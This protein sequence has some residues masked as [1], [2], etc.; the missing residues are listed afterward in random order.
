M[1]SAPDNSRL[2]FITGLA[3]EAKLI[4]EAFARAGKAS[5]R[6][7]CDGPGPR[8]AQAAA[9]RLAAD[10]AV[11]LVSF[12]IC[13][14]LDPELRPGD[15]LLADTILTGDGTRHPASGEQNRILEARLA[16]LGLDIVTGPLLGQDR[17][18]VSAADKSTR[19]AA[20]AALAVDME[21]H[22]VA[23]AAEAAGLPFLTLRAIA[24]PAARSLPQAAL[25]AI[26]P[27]GRLQ[28][29]SAIAAMYLRPWESLALVRLA[30]ETRLAF[31]TL[32]KVAAELAEPGAGLFGGD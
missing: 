5:P 6:L 31:D 27:D 30:Y 16:D 4:E 23:R 32:E 9:A 12:G 15:L 1:T 29:F 14:G 3:A 18:L 10:G 26:G 28:L 25:K 11:L 7:A 20:T 13:G 22:G 21:S 2:G 17:P 8:R 24:D 19:F